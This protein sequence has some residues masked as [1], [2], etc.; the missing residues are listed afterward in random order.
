MT[1]SSQVWSLLGR[2]ELWAVVAAAI[3]L[4]VLYWILRFSPPGSPTGGEDDLEAPPSS[5]RDRVIAGIA[6]GL[7]L[8]ATGAWLAV[9]R[10][11]LWSLPAFALGFG[12]VLTLIA[13]NDRYRHS[14]PAL[15]RT[16]AFSRAGLNASLLAGILIV[17]NVA[18]FRYG[19]HVIDVTREHT[20]SLSS[21][22]RNQVDSLD[23]PV[24]F[25]LVHGRS[26]LAMRQLDRVSELVDL[27]RAARPDLIQVERL[28][29][30][31]E[32]GRLDELA[33]RAP[34][35]AV[36]QGG[37]V[38]IEYGTGEDS[39]FIAVGNNEM[40]ERLPDPRG[41]G[42]GRFESA[43][44]G[45]D[46]VTSA[47]IRLRENKTSR[48]GFTTGHGEP[49]S[50]RLTV[51][52]TGVARWRSRL[53]A[54][55]CEPVVVNLLE[56][57][58]PDDVE[59][60]IVAG[61]KEAF[62]EQEAS[63]LRAYVDRGKPVLL[64]LGGETT[65]LEGFL[66]SF[67]LE[68]GPGVVV[69]P[70]LNLNGR[71]ASIFCPLESSL[72]HPVN[73][74]LSGDRAMLI[75]DASPIH[76]VGTKGASAEDP[77][78]ANPIMLPTPVVRSAPGSWIESTPSDPKVTRDPKET[79]GPIIVAAAV[80]ERTSA[81]DP[82]AFKPRLVL[83]SSRAA[84]DDAVDSI[85]ATNLDFLMNA[86]SWLRGREDSVGVPAQLHEAL[87]LTADPGL[88]WRLIMAPTVVAAAAIVA[89]GA[90]VYAIRR[91]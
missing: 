37:G 23:K 75:I 62:K 57:A 63:Q 66:K 65:G 9:S 76:L 26:A 83:I 56:G 34:E 71:I 61:P 30:H 89:L 20:Y 70:R 41:A 54:A 31:V 77:S 88:R 21:L 29:R 32:L 82:R 86:T 64:C 58:V 10:S 8:I 13:V 73:T 19:G 48:V 90:F 28:D 25:H 55:G 2:A 5:Y 27:Y 40:F 46:L 39:R 3:G 84:G 35:L 49:T 11:L 12:L 43:F 53:H 15:R 69:D 18:A 74:G 60:L 1:T 6:A 80:S 52:G 91:D 22:S 78:A 47:L 16:V 85:E 51:D 14:S 38:L 7:F 17:V 50:Q 68:I 4:L 72:V 24:L 33:R 87:T 36:M 42:S 44:K 79:A 67:N 45:E 59:L 81:S